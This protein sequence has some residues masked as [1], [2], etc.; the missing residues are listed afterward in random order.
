MALH[1]AARAAYKP[2]IYIGGGVRYAVAPGRTDQHNPFVKDDFNVFNGAV[3]IG[4][5]Q[6][7]EWHLMAA[8]L[9]KARAEYRELTAMEA[10]TLQGIRVDMRRAHAAYLRADGDLKAA[11]ESRKLARQWLKEAKEEYEFDSG[12]IKELI[13]AF[14]SWAQIEQNYFQAVYNFNM[15]LADLE[16]TSGGL[17]LSQENAD[18]LQ[19]D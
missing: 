7:L 3:F 6:S 15:S 18:A 4:V 14:E 13:S 8:D 9:D 1:Q 11:R 16:K 12:Q 10:A 2:Q 5:R 19:T 17:T